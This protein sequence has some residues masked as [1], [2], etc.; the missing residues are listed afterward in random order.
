VETKMTDFSM[1]VIESNGE[2]YHSL[3]GKDFSNASEASIFRS[4][5]AA[6]KMIRFAIKDR[7]DYILNLTGRYPDLEA[8]AR[9]LI[10]RWETTA[11][12]VKIA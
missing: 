10:T 9:D 2:Y 6:Q 8:D 11:K 7:K 1:Y 4:E 3:K 5:K 12:V